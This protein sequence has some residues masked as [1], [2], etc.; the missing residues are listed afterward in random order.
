MASARARGTVVAA[1]RIMAKPATDGR[2]MRDTAAR[3]HTD[4]SNSELKQ[5]YAVLAEQLTTLYAAPRR[6]WPAIEAVIVEMDE[7]HAAFKARH[8]RPDDPAQY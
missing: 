4:A 8:A 1:C 7:V 2:S 6:D 3:A 5:R